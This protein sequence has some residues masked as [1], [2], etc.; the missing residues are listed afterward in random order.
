[1]KFR[2]A[3]ALALLSTAASARAALAQQGTVMTFTVDGV[4]R[5]AL[6][7]AP[8]ETKE[9][10]PL[11]FAWHGHGGN[12]R[13]ASQGMHIQTV[14]PEAI[15]VYPQGLPTKSTVD[16]QGLRPGWQQTAGLYGDRDLKF[17][18]EMLA[19]LKQRYSV[20]DSRIYTTGFSNGAVFSYLLWAERGGVIAAVGEVAGRLL[21]PPEHLTQPRALL[22][23]AGRNDTTNPF[24]MQEQT[25]NNDARPVDNATGEGIPCPAPNGSA[26]GTQCTRYPSTTPVKTVFHPGAHVYPPWAPQEIVDFLK[27]HTHP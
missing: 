26:P 3:I 21:D 10:A 18:D 9:K 15:V 23:I 2:F 22:A 20:D 24:A 17:F 13:G 11:V 25:I 14:W 27:L 19:T 8:K 6:V 16:P 5:Q 1:M 12:M 7:F 4:K